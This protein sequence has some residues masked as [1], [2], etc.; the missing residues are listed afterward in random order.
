VLGSAH[1]SATQP[2]TAPLEFASTSASADCCDEAPGRNSRRCN[3][4]LLAE[5]GTDRQLMRVQTTRRSQAGVG[6]NHRFQSPTLRKILVTRTRISVGPEQGS[7]AR[8]E[9]G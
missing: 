5:H 6:R 9:L 4:D 1:P 8:H 2:G 3:G 7:A